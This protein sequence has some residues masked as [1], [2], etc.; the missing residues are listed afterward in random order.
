MRVSP[1]AAAALILVL[2]T[3][4]IAQTEWVEFASREDRFS[5]NFPVQPAVT[6]T[7]YKSQ[8]GADL[9]ARV[10]SAQ[11]GPSRYSL[12]VVDYR[13]LERILT[14]RS[15]SCPPGAEVCRGNT[16]ATSS[17]GAG[18]WKVD[19]AGA[20][21]YATWQFLQRDA[22]VTD[23]LWNNIDFVEGQQIH[24]TNSK[25]QS[26]TLV[27]I[28]MHESKLY[29]LDGTVPAGYPEPGLFQQSL[30]WIDETGTSF[31]YRSLYHHGFPPPDKR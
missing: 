26:R 14:E 10:Y 2:S 24:L 5:A 16:A 19:F 28:Y 27:A 12:T 3:T 9:P 25:D 30:Q 31:R 29:I 17:T 21:I 1:F 4:T 18:Y 6:E 15:K 7:T 11:S 20:V 8:F 22:K 23:F 13:P